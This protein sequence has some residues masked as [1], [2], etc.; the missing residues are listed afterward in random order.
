VF[1]N[2]RSI[3]GVDPD[4]NHLGFAEDEDPS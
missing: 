3:L 1:N 4:G 2:S